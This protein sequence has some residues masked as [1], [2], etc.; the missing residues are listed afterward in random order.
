MS[1]GPLNSVNMSA[2]VTTVTAQQESM[3]SVRQ[4]VTAIRGLNNS[5]L[6]GQGR[7]LT[8]RRDPQTQHP[9]IQIIDQDSG[10]VIDQVPPEAV[11]Q[12]A[13]QLDKQQGRGNS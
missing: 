7:E 1:I 10:E 6:L 8:F 13:A 9:V 5:E 11:L 4:I 3:S 12:L 2:P